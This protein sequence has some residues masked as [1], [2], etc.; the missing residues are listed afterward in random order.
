MIIR[1]KRAIGASILAST[2][3]TTVS[4]CQHFFSA[5][6]AATYYVATT[7]SNSNPGTENKPFLTIAYAVNTMVA[8]DTT[9][10]RGGTYNEDEIR[11]RR[12]GT[13]NAPIRLLN[14][15]NESPIINFNGRTAYH[16]ILIQHASGHNLAMGWITIEGFEIRNGYDGIKLHNLHNG[17]IRRNWIHDNIN[18][19]ILG[20]G[21]HHNFVE[22]NRINHNGDF[23]GCIDGKPHHGSGTVCDKQH[24][25]YMNGNSITIT[26]N[27]IYDNLAFGITMNGSRS[28]E[29]NP[30]HHAGPEFGP[31]H[32]WIIANNTIAY[33]EQRGGLVIWGSRCNNARIENN[34]FYENSV[35]VSGAPQGIEYVGATNSPGVQIRNNHFYASG[36]GGQQAVGG[37]TQPS[38]L[39]FTG[40]IVNVSDPAFVNAPA[41]LPASPNFSLTA[42]SP[43][44]DKGLTITEA[45]I[46]FDGI[47]RPQGRAYDIGA[48]EYNAG[49][50]SQSPARPAGLHVH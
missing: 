39:V 9:Y 42:R 28:A 31:S 3:L 23:Q 46:A 22:R 47:T 41:T 15:P 27:L 48:Y 33:N 6:H 18:Q 11:F 1:L 16:R 7:G 19:G 38:D 26:N 29:Y 37:G 25:I 12:P 13:S 2:L 20:V 30:T 50:D 43:A 32:N 24:G 44:I 35:K 14:Y 17:T 8:G 4:G 21:G 5:A 10:V 36:S 34:I 40:N 49:N 45:K